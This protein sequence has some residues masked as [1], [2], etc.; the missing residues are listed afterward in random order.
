M[1]NLY[2]IDDVDLYSLAGFLP[3]Q[4][5]YKTFLQEREEKPLV[6]YDWKDEHGTE[7]DLESPIV[8]KDRQFV[9]SGYISASSRTDY[10][11]KITALRSALYPTGRVFSIESV[12]AGLIFNVWTLTAPK[13]DPLTRFG[14][15]PVLVKITIELM[16]VQ[17]SNVT[18]TL[19]PAAPTNPVVNDDL[20]T[21]TVTLTPTYTDIQHQFSLNAGISWSPV[22]S[23]MDNG[24]GTVSIPVPDAYYAGGSI[25]VRV[26]A[27]GSGLAGY[28]LSNPLAFTSTS[29][30]DGF[31]GILDDGENDDLQ[32]Y[33]DI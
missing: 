6:G 8:F 15:G 5:C 31:D 14:S 24:D 27:I 7:Y 12:T 26:A 30:E 32:F 1:N 2:K 11:A 22:T 25:R 29:G 4:E 23:G 3:D 10:F 19:R 21:F 18:P 13:Y 28:A 17:E 16:E 20:D 9:L 33:D